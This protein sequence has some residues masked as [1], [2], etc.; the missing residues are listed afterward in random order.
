MPDIN[1]WAPT[2]TWAHETN[3]KYIDEAVKNGWIPSNLALR[4]S[5]LFFDGPEPILLGLSSGTS[6]SEIS[7]QQKDGKIRLNITASDPNAFG[8]PAYLPQVI[9]GGALPAKNPVER[10]QYAMYPKI[11]ETTSGAVFYDA[12]VDPKTGQFILNPHTGRPMQAS[13]TSIKEYPN[14]VIQ[15]AQAFQAS[16]T[17]SLARDPNGQPECRVC[18]GTT[19][20]VKSEEIKSLPVVYGKH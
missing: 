12:L 15:K 2:R 10:Q 14:A 8:C 1:F 18:W 7:F 13:K 11:D 20:N 6:S 16:G 4:P 9:G 19:G 3:R 5:G 17:C